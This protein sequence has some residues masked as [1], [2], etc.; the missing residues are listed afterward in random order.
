MTVPDANSI[1]DYDESPFTSCGA[2]KGPNPALARR[3]LRDVLREHYLAQITCDHDSKQDN[4]VCACSR[5]HL[6]WHSSV[7]TAVDAWITHV[8]TFVDPAR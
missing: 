7:G 8:L 6:G 2:F 3:A 1:M 5:V 4:P